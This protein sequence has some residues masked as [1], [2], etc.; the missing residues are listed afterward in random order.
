MRFILVN[1]R[2]PC[3]RSRC[4]VCDQL[5]GTNYLREFGTD[6]IYCDQNYYAAHCRGADLLLDDQAIASLN[7]R[8]L[9]DETFRS[10]ERTLR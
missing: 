1:G 5:V 8:D 3:P 7:N 10:W 6:L 2:T 9:G 4:V